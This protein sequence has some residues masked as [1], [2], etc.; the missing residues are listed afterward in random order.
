MELQ[1]LKCGTHVVTKM[2]SI[3][4]II[5]QILIE[6]DLVKYN[7]GYFYEGGYKCVCV[8]ECEIEVDTKER[9]NI[10]FRKP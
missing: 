7:I 5:V 2:G 9:V 6:Y 4:A 1:V 10:G 3:P 8:F